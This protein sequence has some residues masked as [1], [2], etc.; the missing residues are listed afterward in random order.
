MTLIKCKK[1]GK[2]ISD[3][4]KT[5][6]HCG[7][8][9]VHTTS[10]KKKNTIK[11]SKC[12]KRYNSSY[13][14]CP[15][16]NPET[17]I[18]TNL[19][20]EKKY[21]KHLD[22]L[23]IIFCIA[24]L[25]YH[26]GFL[27]GGYL[28]VCSFFV[29][30]SYLSVISSF[31]KD[32][33]DL[34]KYYKNRLLK[35]YL[36]VVVVVFMTIP[37]INSLKGLIWINL[38]P[39]TTSVLFGYNNFW[40]I[41]ANLDYFAHSINSPFMHLWYIS[42]LIQYELVFPFIFIA[43]KK[44][45]DK[46]SK[47]LPCIITFSLAII[48]TIYFYISTFSDNM[49]MYYYNTLP[50]AFSLLWGLAFGFTHVYYGNLVPRKT[51][52]EENLLGK[53]IFYLYLIIV[54]LLFIFVS[55]NSKILALSMILTTLITCRLIEYGISFKTSNIPINNYVMQTLS[56]MTLWIYLF[57]YPL[58]YVFQYVKL[59]Q[60]L[61][62]ILMLLILISLSYILFYIFHKE[63]KYKWL[64]TILVT[65]I[66]ALTIFGAWQYC[67]SKD[68]TQEMKALEAQLAENERKAAES[69]KEYEKKLEEALNALDD[70][71]ADVDTALANLSNTI[72]EL[73]I[74][75]I[76]DSI[77][78][79]AAPTLEEKFVNSHFDG[80]VSR[81][82][83]N[84][85]DVI[86][87]YKKSNSLG[88]PIVINL[89]ANGN[90]GE[91]FKRKLIESFGD[92]EIFWSTVT[93][94]VDVKINNDIKA[95]AN[96]YPNLYV[97]D[98]ETLSKGHSEYF[99]VDGIH[100]TTEG[101]LA[102]AN[103]LYDVMYHVYEEKYKKIKEDAINEFENKE[104]N[105][106]SFYGNDILLNAYDLIKDTYKDDAF[107][108]KNDY[109]FNS[110]KNEIKKAI[111][112]NNINNKIV[113]AFDS[114]ISITKDNYNEIINLLGNRQIYILVTTKDSYNAL[115]DYD[116]DNVKIINFY[117][118]LNKNKES[119]L[120]KDDIHLTKEGNNA[121]VKILNK[122]LKDSSK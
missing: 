45:G 10:E 70:T 66:G 65:M 21:Y 115:K 50:R 26:M 52:R 111:E 16:C 36:P 12:G 74:L 89:G 49:M 41:N 102:Y 95:L 106:F 58:I 19:T 97:F 83:W 31:K 103:G 47:K 22:L 85:Y 99:A 8:K 15:Y 34:G 114:S 55:P 107:N 11:C 113:L 60:I 17:I 64:Q 33:F 53:I 110:L 109:S 56:G 37:L 43:L 77:M 105:K 62:T 44:L 9:V 119:Y 25:L 116:Q 5:C 28:A 73:P 40:Q 7:E 6:P 108:M 68:Y 82:I 90:C 3:T 112:A 91:E 78:L 32:H 71:L 23:R 75:G 104:K 29:L 80:K 72:T 42:I 61:K 101:S 57:Q 54:I 94:D 48:G 100:L 38:R 121:F 92:R 69:Q 4:I 27:K 88:N 76:G 2:T 30:S 67:T 117:N 51:L 98:W 93:N 24:I 122:A 59:N 118:E 63:K 81:Q 79:G 18:N 35:L 84:S 39:E 1:C 86:E 87:E 14:R 120:L 46:K 13:D 96:E 20:E